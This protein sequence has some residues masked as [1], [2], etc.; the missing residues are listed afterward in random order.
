MTLSGSALAGPVRRQWQRVGG[1]LSCLQEGSD[2]LTEPS[3]CAAE[4]A[5]ERV[6]LL[7]H[8][9]TQALQQGSPTC[10]SQL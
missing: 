2:T 1:W 10:L 5:E 8:V 3:L 4:A 7:T 9:D 6:Q